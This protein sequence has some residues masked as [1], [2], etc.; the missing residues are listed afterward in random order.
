MDMGI[1]HPFSNISRQSLIMR[2]KMRAESFF[3]LIEIFLSVYN[4]FLL[5]YDDLSRR[6]G[7]KGE[8]DCGDVGPVPLEPH[9]PWAKSLHS[10]M[11]EDKLIEMKV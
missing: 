10:I 6:C 9:D 3:I 5:L 7:Q 1:G 8:G 4:E 2:E 11:N